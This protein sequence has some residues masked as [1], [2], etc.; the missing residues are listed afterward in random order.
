MCTNIISMETILSLDF[1]DFCPFIV[2]I[3]RQPLECAQF[4]E[5][6]CSSSNYLFIRRWTNHDM[7][8]SCSAVRIRSKVHCQ[9]T[10]TLSRC[11]RIKRSCCEHNL[12]ISKEQTN[13]KRQQIGTV[14][15]FIARYLRQ[16][17]WLK[18]CE[19]K[20]FEDSGDMK[21][22]AESRLNWHKL[23]QHQSNEPLT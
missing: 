3:H 21:A 12:I 9:S 16:V 18:N 19:C 4:W 14:F 15:F 1:C 5:P 11:V 10:E 20:W 7:V 6:R 2:Q 8:I 13:M 22:T 17:L 23:S